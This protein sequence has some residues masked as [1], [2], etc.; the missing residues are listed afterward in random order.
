MRLRVTD[1]RQ[2]PPD[3]VQL[4]LFGAMCVPY[5][6]D[7]RHFETLAGPFMEVTLRYVKLRGS[8]ALL[9]P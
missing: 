3:L 4:L 8:S 7:I 2:F 5:I 1:G 6:R 9:G